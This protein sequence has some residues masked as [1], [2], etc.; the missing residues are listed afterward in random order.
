VTYRA[1]LQHKF[2]LS[3]L[4]A[5]SGVPAAPPLLHAQPAALTVGNMYDTVI[6]GSKVCW[7]NKT[8]SMGIQRYEGSWGKKMRQG[9]ACH[10]TIDFI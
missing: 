7:S 5:S 3:F 4:L 8:G 2:P 10:A 6:Q 9:R 1:A